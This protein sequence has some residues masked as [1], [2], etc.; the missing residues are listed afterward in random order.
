MDNMFH[1]VLMQLATRLPT[2]LVY[3]VG[4]VLAISFWSRYPKP[5]L[6]L[7]LSM[8][9]A[10][11]AVITSTFLFVY[12]PRAMNDFGL[13]HQQLVH[14]FWVVGVTSNI[15][16]AGAVVLLLT[17]VFAGRNQLPYRPHWNPDDDGTVE[18]HPGAERRIQG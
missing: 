7:F 14:Y 13:D 16:H 10:L 2:L 8:C 15:V 6:L 12:L 1:T 5:C 4:L 9:T 17:A 11:F 18:L 3:A